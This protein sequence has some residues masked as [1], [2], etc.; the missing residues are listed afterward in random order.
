[1]SMTMLSEFY[2]VRC[3][4]THINAIGRACNGIAVFNNQCLDPMKPIMIIEKSYVVLKGKKWH[5]INI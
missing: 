4:V 5:M 2:A 1:M 3:F